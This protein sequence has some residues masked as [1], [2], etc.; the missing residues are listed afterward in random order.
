MATAEPPVEANERKG[1]EIL[2][3]NSDHFKYSAL[4]AAALDPVHFAGAAGHDIGREL[5]GRAHGKSG[6]GS[7][8]AIQQLLHERGPEVNHLPEKNVPAALGYE[9][10]AMHGTLRCSIQ[11]TLGP[12]AKETEPKS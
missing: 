6:E 1:G 2:G 10:P 4:E 7:N 11:H 8:T 5:I 3:E 9:C 12:I